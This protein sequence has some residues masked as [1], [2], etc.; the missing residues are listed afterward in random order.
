IE[1]LVDG[2][3]PTLEK[4]PLETSPAA[5]DTL[6]GYYFANGSKIPVNRIIDALEWATEGNNVDKLTAGSMAKWTLANN[7]LQSKDLLDHLKA[8]RK[9]RPKA[10]AEQLAE[11]IEAA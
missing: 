2:T 7:A 3:L 5:L 9:R 1:R 6:W 10:V 4:L 8:Q 11:I